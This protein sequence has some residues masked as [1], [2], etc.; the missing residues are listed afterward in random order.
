MFPSLSKWLK[1]SV[2]GPRWWWRPRHRAVPHSAFRL[3]HRL[4]C[5]CTR[6]PDECGEFSKTHC[7]LRVF[8]FKISSLFR[9]QQFNYTFYFIFLFLFLW[10]LLSSHTFQFRCFNRISKRENRRLTRSTCRCWVT[11]ACCCTGRSC[12][13]RESESDSKNGPVKTCTRR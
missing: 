5:Q 8:F 7:T 11:L 4:R 13:M 9:F 1:C 6:L 2:P 10:L 3:R 12:R